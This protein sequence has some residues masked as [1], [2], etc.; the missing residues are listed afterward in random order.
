MPDDD[1][2]PEQRA[3]LHAS[4]DRALEDSEAGRGVDAA[5]YLRR[6]RARHKAR[7]AR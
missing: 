5:E 4:L 6:Y 3:A 1:L 2:D 7:R